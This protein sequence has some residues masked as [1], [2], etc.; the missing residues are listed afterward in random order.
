MQGKGS[1]AS[2]DLAEEFI[3]GVT[4]LQHQ[5][6]HQMKQISDLQ[7]VRDQQISQLLNHHQLLALSLTLPNVQVPIFDGDP[8]EY[9]YFLRSF[10]NLI[11][12][13]TASDNAR[14][15]YLVHI[16]WSEF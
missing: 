11:E 14:L 15:F 12:A 5:Q 16:I 3:R 13:K 6:Q 10:E 9:T 8:I 2:S 4:N 7:D 1:E